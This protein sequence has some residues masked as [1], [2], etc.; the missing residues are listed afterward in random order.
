[1]AI[2]DSHHNIYLVGTA[3]SE[4]LATPG[5]AQTVLGGFD[6]ALLVKIQ[7]HVPP[8]AP[9]S[10]FV[11]E[12]VPCDTGTVEFTNTSL[13]SDLYSWDFGDG[14]GSTDPS[15]THTYND[16]GDYIVTLIATNS[17]TTQSDTFVMT[18]TVFD[19]TPVAVITPAGPTTFCDGGS[20]VLNSNTGTGFTYKWKLGTATIPGATAP[21]YTATCSR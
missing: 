13:N 9:I 6:D 20:V 8:A 4:G 14:F 21:T 19:A 16:V 5:T 12:N 15:P 11:Y 3:G 18:I 1:L 7:L 2:D 10:S 17:S